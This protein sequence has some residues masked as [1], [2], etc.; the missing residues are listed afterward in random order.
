MVVIYDTMWDG[1]KIMANEIAKAV[2]ETG[3]EV[4]ILSIRKNNRNVIM[5]K[6]LDTAAFA[7]GSPTLNS[8]IFPTVADFLAYFKGLRPKNKKAAVFGSYGWGGGAVKIM[9]QQLKNSGIEIIEPE[10]EVKFRPSE[11]ELKRCWP[12]GRQLEFVAKNK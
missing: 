1:T 8:G 9:E 11:E 7:L 10:I 5:K 12:L 6:L 2:E 3:V 4:K